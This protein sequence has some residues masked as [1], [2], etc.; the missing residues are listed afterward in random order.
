MT[1]YER[2][3]SPPYGT[4]ALACLFAFI[5]LFALALQGCASLPASPVAQ[6]DAVVLR[7][8]ELQGAAIDLN[9]SGKIPDKTAVLIV[10]FTVAEAKALKT[11]PV[12][13]QQTIRAS[14][15]SLSFPRPATDS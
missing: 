2:H 6:A 10:R 14:W 12:G 4:I 8:G 15:Q 13:W 5:I 9:A 11:A 3:P 1:A 7:L